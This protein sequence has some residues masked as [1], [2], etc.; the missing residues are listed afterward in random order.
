MSVA[1]PLAKPFAVC[2]F[3]AL[4]VENKTEIISVCFKIMQDNKTANNSC[5][6]I[7]QLH[8]KKSIN[9]KSKLPEKLI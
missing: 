9:I 7:V 2:L 3:T 1:A 5:G 6:Y 4:E 8:I